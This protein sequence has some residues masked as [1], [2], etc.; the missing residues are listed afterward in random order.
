MTD[1]EWYKSIG[2]CVLCHKEKPAPGRVTCLNC[3]DRQ[4]VYQAREGVRE[5]R[6]NHYIQNRDLILERNKKRREEKKKTGIC[7]YCSRQ[8]THGIY[9]YECFLKTRKS[10]RKL[11]EN[12]LKQ[13][14]EKGLVREK[15]KENGLCYLCGYPTLPGLKVCEHHY[16]V[17][18][19]AGEKGHQSMNESV[20]F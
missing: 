13:R 17:L 16:D 3:L 4:S 6:R 10:Q 19:K 9:C 1:Y 11:A 8:A 18:K 20:N 2:L 5:R 15:W 14:H 7:V 12:R